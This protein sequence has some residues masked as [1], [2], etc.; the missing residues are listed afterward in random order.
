MIYYFSC[1][2]RGLFWLGFATETSHIGKPSRQSLVPDLGQAGNTF[3]GPTYCLCGCKGVSNGI[4]RGRGQEAVGKEGE[5][6]R[7]A[8]CRRQLDAALTLTKLFACVSH[9]G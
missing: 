8:R 7:L 3:T 1:C 2:T 5:S 6:E 4:C 9:S